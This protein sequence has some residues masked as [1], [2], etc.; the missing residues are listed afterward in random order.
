[1]KYVPKIITSSGLINYELL[2]P[3]NQIDS[4]DPFAHLASLTQS[5]F[6]RSIE[7]AFD[8]ADVNKRL[9]IEMVEKELDIAKL[10]RSAVADTTSMVK[11]VRV[12][13]TDMP[14]AKN[15]YEWTFNDKFAGSVIKPYAE[16]FAWGVRLFS[17]YCP[18]CSDVEY[19]T[20][21]DKVSDTIPKFMSKVCM[22]EEGKCPA[23][24]ARKSELVA[25]DELPFYQ[26]FAA[27]VGQRSGKTA[28]SGGIFAPY[29]THRVLKMQKPCEVYGI[30]S[31]T[32]LHGTFCAVT[33]AQA[34]ETLWEFYYG[35]LCDS[36]WFREYHGMLDYYSAKYGQT[37]YKLNDTMVTYRCRNLQWYPAG[38]DKRILRGRTRIMGGVDEIAYFDN[39]A[40]SQKIKVSAQGVYS[41][42]DASLLTVR[43][44]AELLLRSGYDNAL[45]GMGMNI[46]SPVSRGDKICQLVAQ[47]ESSKTMLGIKRATW[48]VNPNFT[49]HGAVI[50]DAFVRDAAA[51]ECNYG[52]NPPFVA[53]PYISNTGY[54]QRAFRGPANKLTLQEVNKRK[55]N[56]SQVEKWAQVI[57]YKQ[58]GKP[59]ILS[60]DAGIVNN[61]FAFAV[62]YADGETG[63]IVVPAIG[64]VIP[65]KG[66]PLNFTHIMN[67]VLGP[68]IEFFN[69]KVV[70]ADRW[71]SLKILSDLE[72]V[73]GIKKFVYSLRYKDISYIKSHLESNSLVLP[74]INKEK[75]FDITKLIDVPDDYP[76][77]F[78]GKP[79]KH[80]ALQF[81]TVRDAI[82]QVTKG[83][84]LTDDLFRALTLGVFAHSQEKYTE[85]L[86]GEVE[87]LP[88]E[89]FMV[90]ARF[91]SGGSS[92]IGPSGGSS[93]MSDIAIYR[94][95]G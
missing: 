33:Y 37:L 26:E 62:T 57:S 72:D 92:G 7:E 20:E 88:T 38:P 55:K 39:D 30:A 6:D 67:E 49:R 95:R 5:N 59:S 21:E 24:G 45:T 82:T 41:A 89:Q 36:Q 28:I 31:S 71:Q 50:S 32:M 18:R 29:M 74:R 86:V 51:A 78:V 53:N 81:M 40:S 25:A 54:I 35:T 76:R 44:A 77:C 75:D 15:L 8:P 19:L 4:R 43:G 34:K 14:L 90:A 69:V 94:A 61:S 58:T 1:M 66:I 87:E 2:N 93:N 47:A 9:T 12:D 91:A 85:F 79:M 83:E 48:E 22:L 65:E 70:M 13:D 68:I 73:Y 27:Q 3:R 63:N 52:A 17:E 80:L 42:L 64:E 46:S 23:C 11:D 60:L 16:Q 84:N 56:M 10:V